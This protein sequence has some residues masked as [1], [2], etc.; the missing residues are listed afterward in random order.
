MTVDGTH[1]DF[2]SAGE[3]T[4]LRGDKIEVQARQTP[5]ATAFIPGKTPYTGLQTCVSLYSAVAARV[6]KHRVTYEPNIKGVPD[7][8]GLQLRVDGVLTELRSQGINLGSDGRII[9]P[10]AGEGS[11]EIDYSGGTQLVVV[12]AYW[13]D[14]Q[15]WYLNVNVYGTTATKG[16]FG[17]LAVASELG[18]SWLP[19][20]PDGTSLGPKP[21]SL[22]ERYVE[23]YDRFA[24][25]WRV[26]DSTSLFDYAPGTTT[27]TFTLPQW[28]RENPESCAIPEQPSA[29]PVDVRVA[30]RLCS[31]ITDKDMKTDCIFDVSVTGHKGFARTYLLTQ[32]LR[33]DLTETNV[34]SDEDESKQ[35]KPVTFVATVW[36]K[37]CPG[38]RVYRLGVY[39]SF[40]TAMTSA[41]RSRSMQR[42]ERYGVLRACQSDTTRSWLS[43]SRRA[44]EISFYPAPA[45]R[46]DTGSRNATTISRKVTSR[47]WWRCIRTT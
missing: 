9:K 41:S 40:S 3:F 2:Q 7:P 43:T 45:R 22:H 6:G 15:K 8:T 25:A 16:T 34:R 13:P 14:Q 32:K 5:V 47:G 11:I 42:A 1:Y 46:G 21:T 33:P 4:V 28:P 19:A 36:H 38:A 18:K 39:S 20:L 35:G 24:N 17:Q 10:W 37:S 44:G 12:P 31:P 29:R 27:A 26:K 23:L 30:E